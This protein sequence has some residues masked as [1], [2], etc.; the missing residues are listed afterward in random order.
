MAYGLTI[1]NDSGQLIIDSDLS[2]Y[3][4][5]G[6]YT[7]GTTVAGGTVR[8]HSGGT[9]NTG[10]NFPYSHISP[11]ISDGSTVG[12]IWTYFITLADV[13]SKPPMC[14]IKPTST[15]TNAPFASIIRSW[16]DAGMWKIE[17]L[18]STN[19][20]VDWSSGPSLY[21]F[22]T[23]DQL[24]LGSDSFG[25][26]VMNASNEVTFN[27]Q[28]RPL[29]IV[30]SG[31]IATPTLART[32]S[33]GSNWLGTLDVNCTPNNMTH[34]ASSIDIDKQLY[35]VP[36]IAHCAEQYR[37]TASDSGT[38]DWQSYAWARNDLYWAFYRSAFRITSTTNLQCSYAIYY[39]GHVSRTSTDSGFILSW[40]S[41]TNAVDAEVGST[42]MVPYENSSRNT[43]QTQDVII[44]NSDW[45]V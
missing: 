4:F 42:G 13:S 41:L 3:H 21:V 8:D 32:G 45:Y 16:F 19:T 24:N 27:S 35:Y 28:N 25:L 31:S 12:R 23:L 10:G 5:A 30:S 17:V 43:G 34:S 22:T 26:R 44:T 37:Q 20:F 2:H 38:Y 36:S 40:E 39:R 11:T 6:I 18:Q 9:D 1:N 33:L 29:R 7:P 15:G 14:F